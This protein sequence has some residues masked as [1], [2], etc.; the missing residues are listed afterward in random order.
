MKKTFLSA[1]FAFLAINASAAI[2]D[3]FDINHFIYT[4]TDDIEMTVSVK[5]DPY[6]DDDCPAKVVIPST[7][8]GTDDEEYTVTSIEDR[9]FR[10]RNGIKSISL[11]STITRLGTSAF[12]L[13]VNLT[14]INIPASISEIPDYLFYDCTLLKNITLPAGIIK[15]GDSAFSVCSSLENLALPQSLQEIANYAFA[16]CPKLTTFTLPASLVKIGVGVFDDSSALKT[17]YCMATVPPAAGF[18]LG[19]DENENYPTLYVPQGTIEAYKTAKA[20]KNFPDIRELAGVTVTLSKTELELSEGDEDYLQASVTGIEDLDVISESWSSSNPSVVAVDEDGFVTAF[21][22]GTAFINY[23][24]VVEENDSQ[25]PYSASCKVTVKETYVEEPEIEVYITPYSVSV[26]EGESVD[27]NA[28]VLNYSDATIVKYTWLSSDETV[29]TVSGGEEDA[30][31]TGVKSG[32]AT[33]TLS[34]IAKVGTKQFK[35]DG[36]AYITVEKGEVAGIETKE[37]TVT[38]KDQSRITYSVLEGQTVTITLTP[39][40]GFK[41]LSATFNDEIL[42]P[43]DN[44]VVTPEIEEDSDL[45]VEFA[46]DGEIGFEY[47]TGLETVNGCDFRVYRQDNFIVIENIESYSQVNIYT[48]SGVKLGSSI[49]NDSD[50]IRINVVPGIYIITINGFAIKVNL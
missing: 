36:V 31:V 20:W 2:G 29:A 43:I 35:F 42:N 37:L 9:A 23:T 7:I 16:S 41:V 28:D 46:W 49:S 45:T 10:S 48:L 18:D 27:L 24:V 3:S 1:F 50:T 25:V 6:A 12:S 39:A 15:I 34:V 44:T 21:A 30:V 40:D 33:I 32:K 8:I 11:P 17:L 47:T 26:K 19:F 22:S 4:V 5:F 14:E 13:C 38:V